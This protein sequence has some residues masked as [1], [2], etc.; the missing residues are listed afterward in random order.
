LALGRR[1]ARPKGKAD[2]TVIDVPVDS[3]V[4]VWQHG[5]EM[6]ETGNQFSLTREAS[7]TGG[8]A[9]TKFLSSQ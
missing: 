4:P 9:K 7:I 2:Q 5:E 6:N 3:L 1:G 8:A